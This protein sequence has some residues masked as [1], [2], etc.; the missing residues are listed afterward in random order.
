MNLAEIRKKAQKE[1]STENSCTPPDGPS[2]EK[3]RPEIFSGNDE[4]STTGTDRLPRHEIV[5]FTEPEACPEVFDPVALL[6]AGREAARVLQEIPSD[7]EAVVSDDGDSVKKYLC[8]RVAAEDYAISLMDIKEIIKPREVTEVPRAPAFVKG[9][10]SLRGMIIPILDMR[11]RLG[12]ECIVASGK[13]RFV[14]VKK[15]IGLCGLLVDEVYQVIGLSQHPIEKPP[16]VLE[17]RDREFVS[18]IGRHEERIYILM[19]L[20]KVLDITLF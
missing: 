14:I 2:P 18:G 6:L 9:I 3:E 7:I 4:V 19:D 17:G 8:F 11:V 5:P 12:F 13:E 16:A 1:K 20:E 15:R 10:I